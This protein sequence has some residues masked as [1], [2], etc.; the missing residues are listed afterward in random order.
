MNNLIIF[1]DSMSTNY[2]TNDSVLIE[3]AWPNLLANSL[4]LNLINHSLIGASTGEIIN[5]FF[6][7][8]ECIQS[9]DV[10]I[11]QI[12][13]FNRVL[14]NFKNTTVALGYDTRFS[15]L[16]MDFFEYKSLELDEY[17]AQDFI[18]FEFICEYLSNRNIEFSVW[19]I[20]NMINSNEYPIAYD[21]F[22][23]HF[24]NKFS[25]NFIKYADE[26]SIMASLIEKNP[27]FWINKDDK[28][29]NKT[30]HLFFFQYLYDII[31]S[32]LNKE[33]KII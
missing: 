22:F 33:N 6:N 3:E 2:S 18:K 30:G 10:V 11:L 5:K 17:I 23:K 19:C 27:K 24:Y 28:H 21:R 25:A 7:E 4:N 9:N 13:F 8:Y 14:D 29:F 1:G 16:E 31:L 26:F 12:G 32:R 20:D 15:K